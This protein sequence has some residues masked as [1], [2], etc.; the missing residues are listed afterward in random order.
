MSDELV[1]QL[2]DGNEWSMQE[3]IHRAVQPVISPM[4][5]EKEWRAWGMALYT[6]VAKDK[7]YGKGK[8]LAAFQRNPQG[9]IVALAKCA[10]L[11]LSPDPQLDHFALAP[12]GSEIQGMV[13]YRGWMHVAK[14]AG[15]LEWC[16]ADVMYRQEVNVNAPLRDPVSNRVLHQS[17]ELGREDYSDDDIVGAWGMAKL[18]DSDRIVSVILTRKNINKRRAMSKAPNSPSWTNWFP[19]QCRAKAFQALFRSGKVPLSKVMRQLADEEEIVPVAATVIASEVPPP[20]QPPPPSVLPD[21]PRDGNDVVFDA[22]DKDPLPADVSR[23]GWLLE[24]IG[25]EATSQCLSDNNVLSIGSEVQ[26]VALIEGD[27]LKLNAEQLQA[28]LD[29]MVARRKPEESG[30]GND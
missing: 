2:P 24:A 14:A 15:L 11:G 5:G 4:V 8:L 6:A 26:G 30:D 25:V 17:H 12:F 29:K 20:S 7:A 10:Q 27:L 16:D 9:G 23:Q 22:L 28:I 13:M 3:Y 21:R 19:E 1:V 18:K